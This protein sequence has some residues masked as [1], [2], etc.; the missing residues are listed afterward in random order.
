MPV[1]AKDV[2]IDSVDSMI[3]SLTA[4]PHARILGHS[5][6]ASMRKLAVP[7]EG[8]GVQVPQTVVN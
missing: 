2:T 7:K 6:P 1:V 8:H 3:H 4:S 5:L